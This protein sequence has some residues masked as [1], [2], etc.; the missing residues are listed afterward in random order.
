MSRAQPAISGIARG[1]RQSAYS[2]IELMVVLVIVGILGAIAAAAYDNYREK[3]RVRQAVTDIASMSIQITKYMDE[4]RS[5]PATLADVRLDRLLDPWGRPYQ[6]TNLMSVKG[7]GSARK[8]KRL[9]PLNSDFDL[10]SLGKDGDS[11]L[12]LTPKVSQDDIVRARDGRFIGLAR[13]FDP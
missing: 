2:L 8:D 5:P 12:P 7:K 9:N 4:N 13:D 3:A 10:Y 6:Y 11:K 1:G